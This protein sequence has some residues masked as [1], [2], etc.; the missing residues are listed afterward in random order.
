MVSLTSLLWSYH[1][2]NASDLRQLIRHVTP[3]LTEA[4]RSQPAPRG[5]DAES[6]PYCIAA[7]LAACNPLSGLREKSTSEASMYPNSPYWDGRRI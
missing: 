6:L 4:H 7:K 5:N 1:Q 3:L 2:V